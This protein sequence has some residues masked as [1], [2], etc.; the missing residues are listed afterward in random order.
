LKQEK[1]WG[2]EFLYLKQRFPGTDPGK[3]TIRQ[4]LAI[5]RELRKQAEQEHLVDL[6]HQVESDSRRR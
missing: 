2:T 4:Y 6:L 1:D 5:K 3:L